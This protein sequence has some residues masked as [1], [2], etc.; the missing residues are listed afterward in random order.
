MLA[1]LFLYIALW[2]TWFV[3]QGT[4][5][6]W[7]FELGSW[8]ISGH[9]SSLFLFLAYTSLLAVVFKGVR[10]FDT[11]RTRPRPFEPLGGVAKIV[12]VVALPLAVLAS[13][14]QL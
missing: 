7:Q 6:S 12:G 8:L 14:L 9:Y 4:P 2:I 5:A 11:I 3:L 13:W 1:F 10:N